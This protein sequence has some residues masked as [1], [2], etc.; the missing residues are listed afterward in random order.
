MLQ[1]LNLSMR[2]LMLFSI[3]LLSAIVVT[4]L[5]DMLTA[6][7]GMAVSQPNQEFSGIDLTLPQAMPSISLTHQDPNFY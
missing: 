2:Q 4:V 5:G 1:R 6:Q 3:A 7:P